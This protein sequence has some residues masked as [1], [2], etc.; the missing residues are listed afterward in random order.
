M[1]LLKWRSKPKFEG[2]L[3]GERTLAGQEAKV[4]NG[5]SRSL[6]RRLRMSFQP[7][8]PSSILRNSSSSYQHRR[9][10]VPDAAK[11]SRTAVM[12][13]ANL[14]AALDEARLGRQPDEKVR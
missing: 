10:S 2:E 8:M 11:T 12:H 9:Q 13:W 1:T 14:A 3:A 7:L 4:V 5:I 6:R